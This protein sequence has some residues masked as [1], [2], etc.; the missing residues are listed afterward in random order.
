MMMLFSRCLSVS[1]V[2][3]KPAASSMKTARMSTVSHYRCACL[4]VLRSYLIRDFS[5][6]LFLALSISSLTC[7]H[8][9]QSFFSVIITITKIFPLC[10]FVCL[11]ERSVFPMRCSSSSVF[12]SAKTSC[13][14]FEPMPKDVLMTFILIYRRTTKLAIAFFFVVDIIFPLNR[15]AMSNIAVPIDSL[16]NTRNIPSVSQASRTAH[17]QW[18]GKILAT[19]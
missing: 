4:Y 7:H 17:Y 11:Y 13:V 18:A 16:R 15:I 5:P 9:H 12:L 10:V 19:E 14:S 6:S 8:A 3:D 1:D 2:N